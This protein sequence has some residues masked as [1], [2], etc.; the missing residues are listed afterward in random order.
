MKHKDKF[1]ISKKL[2]LITFGL[3]FILLIFSMLFQILFFED[4]Y[5]NRKVKDMIK[6]SSK[7]STLNSYYTDENILNKA[8]FRF[9]Q[10]TDSRVVILSLDGTVKFLANYGKNTDDF[11]ILTAF[12]AEL[13]NDKYLINEVLTSGKPQ[14]SVF[15]NKLSGTKKIGI[16]SPMSLTSK[17]D[18]I[19]VSVSSMQP[20]NEA[21]GVTKEFYVYL[22][23][24]FSIIA[25]FL[26][27]V[28]ANLI[29]KPLINI[30]KVAKRMSAM[31]FKAKCEVNSDDEIGNL[32]ITLNFLSSTLENALDD[33]KQKNKKLEEDIEK[34]R[35]LEEM[36]KD[37]VASVSHDL[38]TPIG[39]I[40]GYA[41]GLKDGIAT[42]KDA[43]VY[44]DTIIDESHKMNK[45]VTNM[46]ELSKLE[47]GSIELVLEKFNILRLIQ[48]L[49]KSFSLEFDSKDINLELKTD[50]KYCYIIGD[51]FQLE[52]VITNLISNT[53]KYT[54]NGKKVIIEVNSTDSLVNISIEN[55]GAYIPENEIENLYT[56]FYRIDKARTTSNN[57]N[58]LGLA[59]VKRILTLHESSYSLSNTN[60]GVKF[61]FTLKKADDSEI[62]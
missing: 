31:D 9:E 14:A 26:S 41:E 33:L 3:I 62:I 36:R 18:S 57:S 29:S 38:K 7:F 22:F 15:E 35:K 10:E 43:L 24:G 27:F 39:I 12:Y 21:A 2:F 5:L 16:L 45:L 4:F 25:V 48:K 61:E 40:E 1:S 50:F 55:K 42:G 44:L 37:F 56:K 30:N 17:N 28:Y 20:I 19:I 11:Q 13:I 49:I 47:S 54:P 6:E 32:A 52:Q 60:D 51:V 53:L 8:L 23:L 59:I 46:L 34:E 58:G